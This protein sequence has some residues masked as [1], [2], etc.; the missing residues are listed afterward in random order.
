M[1]HLLCERGQNCFNAL[2]LKKLFHAVGRYKMNFEAESLDNHFILKAA[3]LTLQ[4]W[5]W[6]RT[7]VCH[8]I[9]RL[10]CKFRY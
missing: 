1:H 8:Y 6:K 9:D 4:A 5:S 2:R 10:H 7:K 3:C